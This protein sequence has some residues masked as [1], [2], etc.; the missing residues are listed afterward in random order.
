MSELES[1]LSSLRSEI[2]SELRPRLHGLVGRVIRGYLPQ[3]WSFRTEL[4]S[5]SLTVS[6][7]GT[8]RVSGGVSEDHDVLVRWSQKQLTAALRTR[9]KDQIPPGA[10]PSISFRTHRGKTAFSF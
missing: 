5:A 9:D 8:V 7:K 3:V 1:L 2:Q 10:A 6:D 4:E